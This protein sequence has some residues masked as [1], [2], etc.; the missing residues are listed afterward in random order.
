MSDVAEAIVLPKP[1]RTVDIDLPRKLGFLLNAHRYKVAYGGRGSGKSWSFANALLVMGSAHRLR[2]LCAREI[3]RSI[4]HSV[5]ALLIDRIAALGMGGFYSVSDTDIVGGNGTRF[6]FT[7]L[8][9][10]TVDSIKSFEAVDIVWV[11]EGQT[12]SKRSWDILVPTIRVP[13]SEIWVTFN[14]DMEDDETFQRFVVNQRDDA[15]VAKVNYSDNPWFPAVLEAERKYMERT[16]PDDYDNIWLGNCRQIVAGAIFAKEIGEM[17][18]SERYRSVPYDPRLP[19]HTIW[20]LGWNDAM[21]IILVQMP[22]PG[23]LNVISYFE[24]SYRSYTEFVAEFDKLGYRWG[25]DWLPHDGKNKNP[26][27]KSSAYDE[28]R[29]LGRRSVKALHKPVPVEDTIRAARM[30]FPRV[31]IDNSQRKSASGHIGGRR[32]FDCL[33]HYA[34]NITMTTGEPGEPKHDQYSHGA[35]AWRLLA[36]VADQIRN[37]TD[38]PVRK[39]LPFYGNPDPGMGTLGM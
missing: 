24:D 29:R 12:V 4:E 33:K 11:E 6:I 18:N 37:E 23:V 8:A 30:M 15:V 10:H 19:V 5:Y 17:I 2:I 26:I 9:S 22:A 31:Y 21:A 28:L 36:T 32:L 1:Q 35:S 13:G 34:R 14:P 38:R 27:S 16:A 25:T 20:D 3:Q 39:P 7:G